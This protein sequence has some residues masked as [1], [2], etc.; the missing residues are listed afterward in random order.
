[1]LEPSDLRALDLQRVE[2]CPG[3]F[4]VVLLPLALCSTRAVKGFRLTEL[5]AVSFTAALNSEKATSCSLEQ[6]FRS[7]A[8]P[9]FVIVWSNHDWTARVGLVAVVDTSRK[10]SL[11]HEGPLDEFAEVSLPETSCDW[12]TLDKNSAAGAVVDENLWCCLF[13]VLE[14]FGFVGKT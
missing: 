3:V 10:R 7:T 5:F 11:L 13:T 2:N 12:R 9:E 1:M 14:R 6:F 4:V 8:E